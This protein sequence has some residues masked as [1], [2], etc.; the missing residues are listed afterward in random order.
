MRY[1][2]RNGRW[3][4]RPSTGARHL[5]V[6]RQE[7][8]FGNAPIARRYPPRSASVGGVTRAPLD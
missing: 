7:I 2:E 8:D 6:R 5:P 3:P 4:L 1:S